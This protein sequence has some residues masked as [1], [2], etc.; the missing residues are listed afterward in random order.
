MSKHKQD[1][2]EALREKG[3]DLIK[4]E[5]ELISLLRRGGS[6]LDVESY[7]KRLIEVEKGERN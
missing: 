7:I 6:A 2:M 3:V 4:L 1:V 5:K